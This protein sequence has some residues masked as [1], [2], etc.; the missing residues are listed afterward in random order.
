MLLMDYCEGGSL[1][2]KIMQKDSLSEEEIWTYA[3][4]ILRGLA[5]MH[6]RGVLHRF[7]TV[8]L[9]TFL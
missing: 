1:A 8:A 2:V 6:S 3:S 9:P 4:Q 5:H 7:G